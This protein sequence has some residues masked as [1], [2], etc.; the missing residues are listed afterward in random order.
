MFRL[1]GALHAKTVLQ[2]KR[3]SL[4]LSSYKYDIFQLT[5]SRTLE[6][7]SEPHDPH[8]LAPPLK[9]ETSI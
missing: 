9:Q 1:Y 2:I 5:F 8:Q 3:L 6:M 4:K 7:N